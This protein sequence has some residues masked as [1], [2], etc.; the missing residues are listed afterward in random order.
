MAQGGIV[1]WF[2]LIL[3]VA[4]AAPFVIEHY[5][6]VMRD[7]RRGSALAQAQ[8]DKPTLSA[9]SA[10]GLCVGSDH[11]CCVNHKNMPRRADVFVV[12][13]STPGGAQSG[14]HTACLEPIHM[15]A[16]IISAFAANR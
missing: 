11:R 16:A 14:A 2:F 7:G 4:I 9:P 3:A 15:I 5:R 1:I 12:L 6:A 13:K 8:N 10:H